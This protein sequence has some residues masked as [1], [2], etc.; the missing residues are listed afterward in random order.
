MARIEDGVVL[1]LSPAQREAAVAA[2]LR[3]EAPASGAPTGG[4]FM[5]WRFDVR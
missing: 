3:G 5:P 1:F 4:P 2:L